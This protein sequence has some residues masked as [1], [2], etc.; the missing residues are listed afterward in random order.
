ML[1]W[2]KKLKDYIINIFIDKISLLLPINVDVIRILG[3]DGLR[4]SD[5]NVSRQR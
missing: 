2:Y 5:Q 1:E 3:D 4:L